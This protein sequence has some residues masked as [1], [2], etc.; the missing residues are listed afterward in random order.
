ITSLNEIILE[1]TTFA[2]IEKKHITEL[3]IESYIAEV[4]KKSNQEDIIEKYDLHDFPIQV[5]SQEMTLS[6]KLMCLFRLS[7]AE[8]AFEKKDRHFYDISQLLQQEVV[9][10]YLKEEFFLE[11]LNKVYSE[12]KSRNQYIP[13]GCF[14]NTKLFKDLDNILKSVKSKNFFEDLLFNNVRFDFTEIEEAFEKLKQILSSK[15][16]NE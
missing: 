16:V 14:G 4:L 5:L 7:E 9:K 11:D 3:N 2:S 6:E 13:K 12:E 1:S 10:N 15:K 8:K